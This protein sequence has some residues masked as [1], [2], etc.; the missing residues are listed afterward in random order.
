MTI[1]ELKQKEEYS[2][3]CNA[4]KERVL[5]EIA[6]TNCFDEWGFAYVSFGDNIGVEYNLCIDNTTSENINCSA[7]YRTDYNEEEDCIETD[8]STFVHYEIDFNN[9]K[10]KEKLENAM[11]EALIKFFEL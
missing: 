3:Y 6:D 2:W 11:C 5:E 7:I 8:T 1:K 10:W 4:V 9:P